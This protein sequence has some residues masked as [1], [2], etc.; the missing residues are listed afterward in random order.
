[1]ITLEFAKFCLVNVYKPSSSAN[2]EVRLPFRLGFDA[3]FLAY[4]L[5]LKRQLRK[6]IVVCGDF[7]VAHMVRL[8]LYLL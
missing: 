5:D 1:M 2:L 8:L 4:L 7:N 3:A 6:P